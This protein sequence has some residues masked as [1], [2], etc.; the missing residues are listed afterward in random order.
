MTIQ[1]D[2]D[3]WKMLFDEVYL[4]TDARTVC[5]HELTCREIDFFCQLIPIDPDDNLLDFCGG[6]GR[7]SLE[8][9]RRGYKNCTVFD[10][11]RT[12]LGIGEENAG[13]LKC[14]IQ[15]V[16]GDARNSQLENETYDHVM[17]LG[18]SLGYVPDEK[19]D[20]SILSESFR[21]LKPGGWLLL[22]VTDGKAVCES[23]MHNSWHEIG[24]DVVVCR[25]REVN[26]NY[27]CAREM[28]LSKKDGLIRDKNYCIRMFEKSYLKE[29]LI[30]AGF[31][32]VSI[33][34]QN[35][36]TGMKAADLGCMNHRLIVTACKP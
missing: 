7:H 30:D 16:Q 31:T 28:V 27:I 19:S 14:N 12:L 5:N 34:S 18:N 25:Q 22:D 33:Y 8:L 6:H 4:I 32:N 15:F 24:D 10:Y 23:L 21:V 3:W 9:F 1:V 35:S 2:P 11:S 29:L 17:I 26:K 20:L 36:V 13:H